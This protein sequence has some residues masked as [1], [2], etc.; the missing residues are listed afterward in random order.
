MV[1][2]AGNR[3]VSDCQRFLKLD[4]LNIFLKGI[5]YSELN[6]IELNDLDSLRIGECYTLLPESKV[7]FSKIQVPED[8]AKDKNDGFIQNKIV[9]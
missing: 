2:Q 5:S 6:S 3:K 9:N 4:V 8:K 7:R 1:D